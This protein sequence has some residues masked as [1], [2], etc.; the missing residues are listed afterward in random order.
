[1]ECLH[2][3]EPSAPYFFTV[4]VVC[5]KEQGLHTS[6]RLIYR[7]LITLTP[8]TQTYSSMPLA[9]HYPILSD[10]TLPTHTSPRVRGYMC[11]CVWV[12]VRL[13][14][15]ADHRETRSSVLMPALIWKR[16]KC[17]ISAHLLHMRWQIATWL[18]QRMQDEAVMTVK[19]LESI[20]ENGRNWQ[21]ERKWKCVGG[22]V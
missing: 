15:K 4:C 14:L 5:S 16:A 20:K 7:V 1:M 21:K 3:Y 13:V 19:C 12:C 8:I 11:V 22:P 9:A 17:S 2:V 10:I 18:W 6:V